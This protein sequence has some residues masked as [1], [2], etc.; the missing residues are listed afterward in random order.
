LEFDIAQS[1]MD[2]SFIF[3]LY[4]FYMSYL[5]IFLGGLLAFAGE[6]VES[7]NVSTVVIINNLRDPMNFRVSVLSE[8]LL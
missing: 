3:V 1:G 7:R 4:S 6:R 8:N 5:D 2:N